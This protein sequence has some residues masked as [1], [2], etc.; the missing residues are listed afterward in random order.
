MIYFPRLR[1]GSGGCTAEIDPSLEEGI[2]QS[3]PYYIIMLYLNQ[4]AKFDGTRD[5]F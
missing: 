5:L 3:T 4:L 1:R 2:F